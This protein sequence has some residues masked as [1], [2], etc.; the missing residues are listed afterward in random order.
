MLEKALRAHE[1][2][3]I[4]FWALCHV[5]MRRLRQSAAEAKHSQTQARLAACPTALSSA[6]PAAT[7]APSSS[8]SA[9]S[10]AAATAT[11]AR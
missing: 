8:T 7:A 6:A 11:E 9:A 3:L 10:A 1:Q 2:T 5:C 4:L